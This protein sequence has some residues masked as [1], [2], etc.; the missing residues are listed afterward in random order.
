MDNWLLLDVGGSVFVALGVSASVAS[1]VSV[2]FC[3][4]FCRYMKL[5]QTYA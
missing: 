2:V 4:G 3:F 1:V 5:T